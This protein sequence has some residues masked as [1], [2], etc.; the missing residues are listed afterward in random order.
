MIDKLFS[1]WDSVQDFLSQAAEATGLSDAIEV[2]EQNDVQLV[3][4]ANGRDVIVNKRYGTVM[5]ESRLLAR[6]AAIKSVDIKYCRHRYRGRLVEWWVVRLNLNWYS[7]VRIGSTK[8][9]LDAAI[10]AANLG[11]ATGKKVRSY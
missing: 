1:L 2:I 4:K 8:N 5:A 6:T 10:A 3:L 9:K 7:S 11:T